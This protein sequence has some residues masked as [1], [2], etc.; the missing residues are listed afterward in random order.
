[1]SHKNIFFHVSALNIHC[2]YTPQLHYLECKFRCL[3]LG[4]SQVHDNWYLIQNEKV[5]LQQPRVCVH[6]Y[7]DISNKHLFRNFRTL[8]LAITIRTFSAKELVTHHMAGEVVRILVQARVHIVISLATRVFA[9][10][11]VS[12]IL[13]VTCIV[14][15]DASNWHRYSLS[16]FL[17]LIM[18]LLVF[19]RLC[20]HISKQ[21]NMP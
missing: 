20:F 1:M 21:P 3:V 4:F 18:S 5:M 19:L 15:A 13:P 2:Y 8:K 9:L 12:C 16:Y 14:Y 17:P 11:Y 10:V 6:G 7:K